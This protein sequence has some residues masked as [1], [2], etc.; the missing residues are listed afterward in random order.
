MMLTSAR[1][2]AITESIEILFIDAIEYLYYRTLYDFILCRQKTNRAFLS[3]CLIYPVS[4]EPVA[5]VR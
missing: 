3:V 5:G 1:T 2:K 4:V